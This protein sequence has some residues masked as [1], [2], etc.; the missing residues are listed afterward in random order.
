MMFFIKR[1][2]RLRYQFTLCYLQSQGNLQRTGEKNSEAFTT[3]Q[4]VDCRLG[5]ENQGINM[6]QDCRFLGDIRVIFQSAG[7]RFATTQLVSSATFTVTLPRYRCVSI[8]CLPVNRGQY[9]SRPIDYLCLLTNLSFHVLHDVTLT[10][11][12]CHLVSLTLCRWC[13]LLFSRSY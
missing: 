1:N 6:K 8:R 10:N 7:L 5:G 13:L 12:H 2:N 11:I 9:R 4:T 3:L